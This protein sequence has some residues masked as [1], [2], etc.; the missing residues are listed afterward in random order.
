[1]DIKSFLIANA[2]VGNKKNDGV[3]EFAYQGPTY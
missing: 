3:I 1:M 2:L